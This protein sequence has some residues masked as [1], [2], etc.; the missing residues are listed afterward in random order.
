MLRLL[1]LLAVP[2]IVIAFIARYFDGDFSQHISAFWTAAGVFGGFTFAIF[3]YFLNEADAARR[4]IV[5]QISSLKDLAFIELTADGVNQEFIKSIQEVKEN[6]IA[7]LVAIAATFSAGVFSMLN[8]PFIQADWYLNSDRFA[9]IISS[10]SLYIMVLA[11]K[12]T[13]GTTIAVHDYRRECEIKILSNG[14]I[15]PAPT[16]GSV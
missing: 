5:S 14:T 3:I 16:E 2:L 9:F 6:A 7:L 13:L 4:N 12:D 8:V 10:Y 1:L 15:T 11:A